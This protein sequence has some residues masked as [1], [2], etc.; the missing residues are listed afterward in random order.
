MYFMLKVII[1]VEHTHV[2]K[3]EAITFVHV[4]GAC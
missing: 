3:V 1:A 2:G 4:K